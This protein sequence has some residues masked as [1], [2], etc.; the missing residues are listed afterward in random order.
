ALPPRRLPGEHVIGHAAALELGLDELQ[1][2]DE[3]REQQHLVAFLEQRL[4]ELEQRLELARAQ[5]V[6]AAGERRVAADLAEARERGEHRHA[7]ALEPL[8]IREQRAEER[9]RPPQLREVEPPL[10]RREC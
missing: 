7:V 1:A 10:S 4:Q 8:R 3:L 2:L 5:A 6:A 9:P